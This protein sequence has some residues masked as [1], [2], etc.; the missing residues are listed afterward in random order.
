M[1]KQRIKELS[2]EGFRLYG[3]FANLVNPSAYQFGAEPI[4]FFRDMLQLE[5]GTRSRASFSVC[6][7]KRRPFVVDKTEYHSSCGEAILPLDSDV[8]IHVGPATPRGQVPLDQI[9]I[10]RLPKATL[11]V[12]RPG[13]WHHAPFAHKSDTANVLIVLPERAYANDCEVY[14]VPETERIEIE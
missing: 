12:L 7:V 9:E 6:R 13:V 14:D 1:R 10:F 5:L 4:Q 11:A 8:L 3:A 2:L